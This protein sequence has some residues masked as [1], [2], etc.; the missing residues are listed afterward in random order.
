MFKVYIL[1][2]VGGGPKFSEG[3]YILQQNK[4]WGVLIYQK[5]RSGGTNFEGSIFTMTVHIDLEALHLGQ[6]AL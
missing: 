1:S 6:Q 5:I 2:S 4:F 3:V